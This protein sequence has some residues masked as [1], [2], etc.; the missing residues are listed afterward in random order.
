[1]AKILLLGAGIIGLNT[2]LRLALETEHQ[3]SIW[4][5][6]LTDITSSYAGAFW[7]P[8]QSITSETNLVDW[9]SATFHFLHGLDQEAGVVNR[10]IIGL[11][12]QP[13]QIP[14]WFGVIPRCRQAS[15]AEV[16]AKFSHGLVIESAPVIDPPVHLKWLRDRLAGLAIPIQL[17]KVTSLQEALAQCPIVI[18]CTGIG[19][20]ELCH[21]KDLRPVSG[22]LVKIRANTIDRVIFVGNRPER[23]AYIVPHATHTIL[24][25][26]YF[27]DD[28][29]TRLDED[30]VLAILA[31]CNEL[32]PPLRATKDDI[33]G[34]SKAP[35]PVRP[36]LRLEV[37]KQAGGLVIHNYGQGRSGFSLAYGC[38][39]E[40]LRL[41]H[42]VL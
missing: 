38:A 36:T 37:E 27:V 19:A 8:T 1:M 30:E 21:D 22:Q 15:A 6:D 39:G 7:W 41:L 2:A 20:R 18:N 11:D 40:V 35:R 33:I 24:G 17:R 9:G 23:T 26:T 16:T 32:Y 25:G 3:V 4:A 34:G 13:C 10:K 28:F 12:E 42:Q 5:A 31:R 14:P 29:Q